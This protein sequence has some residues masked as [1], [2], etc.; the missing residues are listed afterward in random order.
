MEGEREGK[1]EGERERGREGGKDRKRERERKR[2]AQ[3]REGGE[4]EV[5]ARERDIARREGAQGQ[6]R[7]L[8]HRH[9]GGGEGGVGTSGRGVE[10]T[11]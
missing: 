7:A 11:V 2:E 1:R 10:L 5:G 4:I 9:K 3:G 6:G 8:G